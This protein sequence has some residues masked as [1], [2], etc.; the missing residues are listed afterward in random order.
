MGT[1][2]I[3][4]IVFDYDGTLHDCLVIF[5]QAF[6]RAWDN[7]AAAGHVEPHV[8]TEAERASCIGLTYKELWSGLVPDL[9]EKIWM[10]EA[11]EITNKMLQ[12]IEDG[13]ARLY[14]GVPEMLQRLKDDGFTLVFLSNCRIPYRDA[15]RKRFSLDRW[16][17]AYFAGEEYDFAPK[18]DIFK[19]HI[20]PAFPGGF[21]FVGDRYKDIAAAFANDM[22]CVGCTYGFGTREEL[23]GATALADS[24]SQI[25]GIIEA[26]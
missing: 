10:P 2:N 24:P 5:G 12:L 1:S 19:Q 8:F 21:V 26:L 11:Q 22:P 7:L 4:T 9:P 15:M 6:Q 18:A 3:R 25:A 13:T 17:S 23:A 16:F 20:E 14:P